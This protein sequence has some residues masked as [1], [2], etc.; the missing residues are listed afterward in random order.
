MMNRPPS[1]S[2]REE[3]D[4]IENPTVFVL[5]AGAHCS[6]GFPSGEIL[7]EE[8]AKQACGVVAMDEKRLL[9]GITPELSDSY[10]REVGTR[11][12]DALKNSGQPSIDAFLD[13][14]RDQPYY[15]VIGKA[16]IAYIL[17]DMEK[18]V[19]FDGE[20]SKKPKATDGDDWLGYL[21]EQ[22]MEG[23]RTPAQFAENKVRFITFNYDRLLE[24]WLHA[25]IQ[26]SFSLDTEGARKVLE[27]IPMHHMYGRLGAFLPDRSEDYVTAYRGIRTI[28]DAQH[29]ESVLELIKSLLSKAYTIC[30]LGFGF[31]TENVELINLKAY[32]PNRPNDQRIVASSRYG[33]TATEWERMVRKHFPEGTIRTAIESHKCLDALRNLP[34][35]S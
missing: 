25:R 3:N 9:R 32:L 7:K 18:K 29:D 28:F 27:T 8:V 20:K 12:S 6:Y 24:T 15:D 17:L 19:L 34:I 10:M 22:M 13:A 16:T 4:V 1:G 30:I 33:I 21:F 5:G 31:H 14:H 2:D 23:V 35:F 26:N 11:F